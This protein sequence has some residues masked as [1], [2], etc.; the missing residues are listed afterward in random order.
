M[1]HQHFSKQL[2]LEAVE[3][4]AEGLSLTADMK[5][6]LK[7]GLQS[8]ADSEMSRI[9]RVERQRA[10]D[11]AVQDWE[12]R[13]PSLRDRLLAIIEANARQR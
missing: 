3:R 12:Q 8:E 10:I 4:Q 7:G 13:N 1:P 2:F 5:E 11:S 9:E 6:A